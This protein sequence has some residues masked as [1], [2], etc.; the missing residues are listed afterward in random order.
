MIILMI[1][2]VLMIVTMIIT[3]LCKV[4]SSTHEMLL[5]TGALYLKLQHITIKCFNKVNIIAW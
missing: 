3:I 5:S 4:T 2:M 1:I